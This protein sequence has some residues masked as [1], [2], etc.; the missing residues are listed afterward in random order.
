MVHVSVQGVSGNQCKVLKNQLAR[1][2]LDFHIVQISHHQY[3]EK[4]AENLRQKLNLS[5]DA[6]V[7]NEKELCVDLGIVHANND[8]S[9]SSSWAQSQ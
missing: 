6:Q 5:E 3:V 8:E 7:L 9:I 1:I 4:V 2:R